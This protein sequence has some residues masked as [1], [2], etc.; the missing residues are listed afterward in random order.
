MRKS[1]PL[2]PGYRF[3]FGAR[4]ANNFRYLIE[5]GFNLVDYSLLAS[6]TG[7]HLLAHT[8]LMFIVLPIFRT[9]SLSTFLFSMV[10]KSYK[11][12]SLND[13][14]I[15]LQKYADTL[16]YSVAAATLLL[17]FLASLITS[18]LISSTIG[19]GFYIG[20][21][22]FD[23][24]LE[25]IGISRRHAAIKT[26]KE[27]NDEINEEIPAIHDHQST[28][29][30]ELSL[31]DKLRIEN[32]QALFD[33]NN[34]MILTL[35]KQNKFQYAYLANNV[36]MAI[37]AGLMVPATIMIGPALAASVAL[38]PLGVSLL[39]IS[40]SLIFATALFGTVHTLLRRK[41]DL[42]QN[43]LKQSCR[44]SKALNRLD[45]YSLGI[46][47]E[48]SP[49]ID[50]HLTHQSAARSQSICNRLQA[51]SIPNF[52]LETQVNPRLRPGLFTLITDTNNPKE[53]H[54]KRASCRI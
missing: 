54:T 3:Y 42:R 27:N 32:L 5:S 26:L 39:L 35:K 9:I 30:S 44:R 48:F 13:E 2:H 36:V 53:G 25:V 52:K 38:P 31:R 7:W 14:K 41:L 22:L 18:M 15:F 46:T 47:S 21:I 8:P 43:T 17:L 40:T 20:L 24:A 6:R 34:Q 12:E 28:K 49:N 51:R 37:G 16:F 29:N 11:E 19:V 23:S 50:S 4:L 45:L 33:T 10:L 1:R